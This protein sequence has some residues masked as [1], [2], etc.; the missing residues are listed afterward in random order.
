MS[1]IY[2]RTFKVPLWVIASGKSPK[3]DKA[4]EWMAT[5]NALVVDWPSNSFADRIE[6]MKRKG[7]MHELKGVYPF[8]L[9]YQL[10]GAA[11]TDHVKGMSEKAYPNFDYPL[12]KYDRKI[13]SPADYARLFDD[14]LMSQPA[15]YLSN[16]FQIA[17]KCHRD[18]G[19]AYRCFVTREPC[20]RDLISK[21][22][23]RVVT[24]GTTTGCDIGLKNID[25]DKLE[26]YLEKR[27]SEVTNT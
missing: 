12:H 24:M 19:V 2:N 5:R 15:L 26:E 21:V 13:D 9:H 22:A 18:D 11:V 17:D 6:S 7:W 16:L 20:N 23:E 1:Q 4:M 25:E 8:F 14:F 27:F 3:L 10:L